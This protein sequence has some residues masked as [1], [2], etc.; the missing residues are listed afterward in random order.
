MTEK[1]T[2]PVHKEPEYKKLVVQGDTYLT[3]YN[4]KYENRKKW[5]KPNE[6]EV[7]SIIPGT[8]RQVMVKVGDRVTHM[9]NILILEAMKMMNTITSP[10]DGK[11][12]S[13]LVKEGDCIPK[14]TLMIE[15][16]QNDRAPT[17]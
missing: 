15:I 17:R 4:K 1:K 11:I 3:T 2:N 13:I 16:D 14:G 7:I 9:D 5:I 6:N 8:I 12:K 10:V